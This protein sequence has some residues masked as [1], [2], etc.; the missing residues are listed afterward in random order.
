MKRREFIILLGGAV[1]ARPFGTSA[2]QAER[3]RR[4][5]VLVGGDIRDSKDP[6][7]AIFRGTLQNLGWTDG[8]NV[9]FDYRFGA[10]D[11][12]LLR[13]YA[14]ELVALKPDV[15]FAVGSGSLGPLQQVTHSV[16]IVFSGVL[17]PVA[18]GFVTNLARP[19]GNV[20]GFTNFD[21]SVAGKWLDLLKEVAPGV[22][23]VAVLRDPT[24]FAGAGQLG[25]IQAAATSV[26]VELRPADARDDKEI[27]R[28]LSALAP[29]SN[30]GLIVQSG[31][32]ASLHSKAI[33]ALS[34]KYRVPAVYARRQDVADGGLMSYANDPAEPARRAAEYTDRILKGEKPADLPVQ[35]PTKYNLVINIKAAKAIGLTVPDKLLALADEVIE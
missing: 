2:Q 30:G 24:Q 23:R 32:A 18:Q 31:F 3:V 33:V 10:A 20:T 34:T 19:G 16:P 35:N 1:A 11:R 5:G 6:Y 25:A 21:Y 15:I 22:K 14:A 28:V 17:D 13:T 7:L 26:G 29:V 12:D 4:V 9:R 8:R 27:E